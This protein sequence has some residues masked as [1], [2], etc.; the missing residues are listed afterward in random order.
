MHNHW[1]AN[2]DDLRAR[3]RDVITP[4]TR[5][6][7]QA[8]SV[9]QCLSGVVGLAARRYSLEVTQRACADLALDPRAWETSLGNLPKGAD[10]RVAAPVELIAAAARGFVPL[11]GVDC[12]RT[13]LA[14]WASEND[15]AVWMSLSAA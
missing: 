11:A 9:A 8:R 7:E 15:P 3:A 14:F 6:A 2:I 13:A 10:G 12:L 5:Q 1:R 4:T